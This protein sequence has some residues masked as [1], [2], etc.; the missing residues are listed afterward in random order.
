MSNKTELETWL[1]ETKRKNLSIKEL[2]E[3]TICMNNGLYNKIKKTFKLKGTDSLADYLFNKWNTPS[4]WI[5][6]RGERVLVW[7]DNESDA[8]ERIFLSVL[9]IENLAHPICVVAK[10]NESLYLNGDKFSL[11]RY[12]HMKQ[13]PKE[14]PKQ[15]TLEEDLKFPLII[16]NGMDYLNLTTKIFIN[17]AKWQAEKILEFLYLEI[18]ERRPYSSSK[19]CEVVIEFIEQLNTKK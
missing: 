12:P 3:L 6:Q 15:E 16:E 2:S 19:M 4:E 1:E 10:S 14:E 18:T 9:D 11:Q 8:I 7:D 5:P 13:L 17:G